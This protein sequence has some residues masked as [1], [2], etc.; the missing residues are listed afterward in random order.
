MDI[1]Q[2]PAEPNAKEVAALY[3]NSKLSKTQA[4]QLLQ[5]YRIRHKVSDAAFGDLL[6]MLQRAF[7]PANNTL[8]RFN[9]QANL[10]W[11]LSHS[12]LFKYFIHSSTLYSFAKALDEDCV[13]KVVHSTSNFVVFD[14]KS[15]INGVVTREFLH[16]KNSQKIA[17]NLKKTTQASR[18]IGKG[19]GIRSSSTTA[20]FD[21]ATKWMISSPSLF[22]PTVDQ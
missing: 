16:K 14:V 8:P 17:L 1:E 11:L 15:Q 6:E 7:L 19:L 18:S 13:L 4:I 3:S 10:F 2:L 20:V 9:S 21:C 22:L 12:F 5:L